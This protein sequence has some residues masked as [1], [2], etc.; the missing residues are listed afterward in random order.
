MQGLIV[1]LTHLLN[2]W[3]GGPIV[4]LLAAMRI[5]VVHSAAPIN[6]TLTLE[7]LVM[8][9]LIGFFA[10]VRLTLSVESPGVPQH[11]AEILYEFVVKQADA[12]MGRDFEPH[13]VFVTTILLFTGS[14]NLVGLLPGVG[15]PT[16]NPSVPLAIALLTFFYSEA[17]SVRVLGVFGYVKHLS[18]PIWWTTPLILPVEIV[19]HLNRNVSLT[20]RL[21]ANMFASDLLTLVFFSL[22]PVGLPVVFLGLHF[23]VAL[24][25]CY[26]FMLLALIYLSE[27]NVDH[28]TH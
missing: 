28:E 21:Y 23:G 9:C 25:Q 13:L 15:T 11:L 3:L 19:S 16:A 12:I 26:V 18:G 2:Q 27:A 1:W 7:L 6:P 4:A 8:A 10:T 17:H 24:I 20:V 14:C 22:F 5:H